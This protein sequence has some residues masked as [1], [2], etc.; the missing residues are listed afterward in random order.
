MKERVMSCFTYIT[1]MNGINSL[2]IRSAAI[3]K[4]CNMDTSM[5]AYMVEI[6][7]GILKDVHFFT[8]TEDGDEAINR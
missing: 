2:K 3:R 6:V 7:S 8:Y 5:L 4:G 1:S